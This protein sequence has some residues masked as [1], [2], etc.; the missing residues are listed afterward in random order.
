MSRT[1]SYC[2]TVVMMALLLP[3]VFGCQKTTPLPTHHEE[4]VIRIR[5]LLPANWDLTQTNGEIVIFRKDSV[6][7]H[8][9]IGLDLSWAR[10]RELLRQFVE[11]YGDTR[12]YKIR[13]RSGSIVDPQEYARLKESNSQIRV[14]KSTSIQNREFYEDG[15]MSSFDPRYRQLPDYYDSHSSIY[16]ETTMHPW[17]CIYPGEVARDCEGVL[18]ALDSIFSKYPG[19]QPRGGLSWM[20]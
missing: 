8:G 17:E 18:R 12:D 10:H 11:K 5:S 2:L 3:G 14:T 16:L 15:A 7:T 20:D 4:L 6:R 9:C 1:I 13:L 19:A